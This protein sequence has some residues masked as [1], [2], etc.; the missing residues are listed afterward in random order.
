MNH[1]GV[2]FATDEALALRIRSLGPTNLQLLVRI[3]KQNG[4][5]WV[6][7]DA[8]YTLRASCDIESA[9]CIELAAGAWSGSDHTSFLAADF[10]DG[11]PN[12]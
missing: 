12:P 2:L 5:E 4:D 6:P 8:P 3:E 1:R 11:E 7:L 10:S 9:G